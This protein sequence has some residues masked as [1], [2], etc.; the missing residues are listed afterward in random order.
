MR[1]LQRGQSAQLAKNS[2][3]KIAKVEELTEQLHSRVDT[4]ENLIYEFRKESFTS[5]NEVEKLTMQRNDILRRALNEMCRGL[6]LPSPL[7]AYNHHQ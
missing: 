6:N 1:E 2:E 3:I 5:I 4:N 7:L